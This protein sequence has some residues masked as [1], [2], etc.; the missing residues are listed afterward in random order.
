MNLST[1]QTHRQ[2]EQACGT[3]G[4]G[5]WERMEWEVGMS[6]CKLSYT[7]GI[8]NSVLLYSTEKYIQCLITNHHRK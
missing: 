5:G 2:G 3:Q 1:K 8:N 4:G 7:E 6:R